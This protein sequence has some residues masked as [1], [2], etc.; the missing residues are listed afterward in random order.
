MTN[1]SEI[2]TAWLIQPSHFCDDDLE[3][4]SEESIWSALR[5]VAHFQRQKEWF[6]QRI[7]MDGEGGIVMDDFEKWQIVQY[8][9]DKDGQI[10]KLVFEDSHLVSRENVEL[11]QEAKTA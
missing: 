5:L 3:S 8:G 4:P 9:I 10:E 2:L 7:V 11:K 6:P 1:I